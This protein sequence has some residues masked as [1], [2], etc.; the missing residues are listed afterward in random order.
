MMSY[1]DRTFCASKTET[2]TCGREIT[3]EHKKRAEELGLPISYT[4][5]C[6]GEIADTS[7]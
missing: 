3:E 5:F 7:N 2:H 4:F 6:G 1:L